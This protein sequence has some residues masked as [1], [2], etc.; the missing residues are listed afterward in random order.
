ML[1]SVG[2]SVYLLMEEIPSQVRS[3]RS[4]QAD[5]S[6]MVKMISH[7]IIFQYFYH[8]ALSFLACLRLGW[9]CKPVF[10]AW[11]LGLCRVREYL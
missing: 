10:H 11:L 1:I 8:G 7:S 6:A 4:L 9:S 3:V 2:V 5:Y